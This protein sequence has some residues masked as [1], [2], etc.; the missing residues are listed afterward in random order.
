MEPDRTGLRLTWSPSSDLEID[1]YEVTRHN[2]DG[3]DT[4][5]N[6]DGLIKGTTISDAG[7]EP[8]HEYSYSIA[9]I[10]LQG[11]RSESSDVVR[12]VTG[13]P[14]PTTTY[15]AS[16]CPEPTIRVSSMEE[17]R[18]AFD[19]AEPGDVIW[20]EDGT[21]TFP[22]HMRNSG[23][24]EDPIWICGSR[25][26]IFDQSRK[27]RRGAGFQFHGVHDVV[28]AGFTIKGATQGV[29][30]DGSHRIVVADLDISS[31]DK[32]GI[33]LRA[34]TTDSYVIGNRISKTGQLDVRYGEGIY[35]GSSPSN[36]CQVTDCEPDRSDRNIIELNVIT[37]TTA[38]AVEVKEQVQSGII[39][40][41]VVD[42]STM[43]ARYSDALISVRGD[44][45][46][47]E[48]NSGRNSPRHGILSQLFTTDN[49]FVGNTI[50]SVA[51]Y[52]YAAHPDTEAVITCDNTAQDAAHGVYR[53]PCQP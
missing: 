31:I 44:S 2:S 46:L 21:Y 15:R 10:D 41:N 38:E 16:N 23:T 47:V 14:A 45:W 5:L 24:S 52:A 34:N 39:R 22:P 35:V 4:V 27:E 17:I 26:T 28:I 12:G 29:F 6:V 13:R 19:S 8:D 49:H 3:T 9:A 40:N 51:E 48:E 50:R 25:N 18:T 30:V 11:N 1:G 32:E 36:W 43:S 33:H 53:I 7:L 42:G 37:D 20:I